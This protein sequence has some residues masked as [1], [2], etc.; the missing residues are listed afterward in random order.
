MENWKELALEASRRLNRVS[1]DDIN[2][3]LLDVADA[4]EAASF[5][6]L[7]ANE[8]DLAK[9]DKSN[10][11]YDR[12]MLTEERI[13]GIAADMRK[14]AT[15]PSPL[16][17]VLEE[18]TLPNGLHLVKRSVPFGVIGIIYEARPNV[19]FD[20]FSLCLKSGNVCVLKGGTDAYNSNFAIVEL[21]KGVLEAHGLDPN[22][23]T[24]MPAGREAT[25]ELMDAVGYVDLIIPRGGA[26]LIKFVREN[27]KVPVIETGAGVVHAYY[28]ADADLVK[29][30][31]IIAN[32]KTRR[33]SVCN[34]LDTLIINSKRLS[35]LPEICKPLAEKNVVIE[36]DA[37]A[38]TFLMGKYPDN[39]LEKAN[40][41][42]FG[43]EFMDYRMGLKTVESLDE[44]LEH[45]ARFSSKHSECI[46]T[47]NESS[48]VKFQKEVDAACVYVNAPTSFT[49]GAQFGMGAEI[50]I[51]T[52]KLHARGP[53]ALPE[54]TTYKWLI[55][56]NGQ[57]RS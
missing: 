49:D 14:V 40:E 2:S 1:N 24:L 48:A 19:S 41:N 55:N 31:A 44:A 47:E 30:T 52:Q 43:K 27:S 38:Y 4:A 9:M 29:G 15:L 12:L 54:L 53:M 11:M 34:A 20:V 6:L 57:T 17:K 13:K 26:G 35:D 10:P 22:I 21:I 37:K 16:D 56:G 32:A 46:I 51:S 25:A 45:I 39:L 23:I 42:T 18:R 3:V 28:D 36:A 8:Q 50:G 5:L 33:V 7:K